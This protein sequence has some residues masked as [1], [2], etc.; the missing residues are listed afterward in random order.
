M[1]LGFRKFI[2]ETFVNAKF[3]KNLPSKNFPLYGTLLSKVLY[4][5]VDMNARLRLTP[6]N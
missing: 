2:S 5:K 1:V 3:S 6:V 4:C